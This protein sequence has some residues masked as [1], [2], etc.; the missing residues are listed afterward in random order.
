MPSLR[1]SDADRE[2]T[3]TR[4]NEHAATGR[5]D[6]A[7]LSAR[8]ETALAART[9]DE[10]AALTTDLPAVRPA[11]R[12]RRTPRPELAVYLAVIAGLWV[13]WAATGMGHPWPLWPMLGWGGALLLP[14]A[15]WTGWGCYAAAPAGVARSRAASVGRQ[16]SSP[17]SHWRP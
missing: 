1:A 10:L 8:T 14:R 9:V 12:R 4:L 7:E 2:R 5:L 13:T 16:S 3:V 11:E 15:A 17:P 6:V